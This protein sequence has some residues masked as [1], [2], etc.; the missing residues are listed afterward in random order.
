MRKALI[1][2]SVIVAVAVVGMI[3]L[4]AHE[5]VESAVITVDGMVCDDC[6]SKVE[7]ALTSID[8]VKAAQASLKD[9]L[10]RV[11][12]VASLT[13][14]P[15]LE[16]AIAK[17]GYSAGNTRASAAHGESRR[18]GTADKACDDGG[19][20]ECCAKKSSQPTT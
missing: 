18:G 3:L 10:V 4:S 7:S 13:D 11:N 8:G 16:K 9:N 5:K 15:S 19:K 1:G 14:V 12:Y 6:V 2:A 17:L 20:S